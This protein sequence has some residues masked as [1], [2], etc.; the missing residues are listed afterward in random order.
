[1]LRS[2]HSIVRFDFDRMRVHPDRLRRGVDDDYLTAAKICLHHYRGGVG[3]TRQELHGEV[4]RTLSRVSG[5]PPRRIAAFCKLLDDSSTFDG[6]RKSAVKL[7][8]RVFELAAPLHPIVTTREG[9]FEHDLTTARRHVCQSLGMTWP[10]IESAMFGDVVEL[11][12]LQQFDDDVTPAE[13][14]S[15]YNVAQTQAVL[16]RAQRMILETRQDS[17]LILGQIKLAGLMHR[18]EKLPDG[19]GGYRFILDGPASGLRQTTRYGV[20]FAQMI[21]TLLHVS[22]WRLR[23]D[24]LTTTRRTMAFVLS[25]ADRLRP[26]GDRP[27]EFDSELEREIDAM[28]RADPVDD[29]TWHR[30][31]ELLVRGQSVL[32]PDFVAENCSRRHRMLV[33]V[34]GFWTPEYIAEKARRLREFTQV[35]AS[36]VSASDQAGWRVDWLLVFDKGPIPTEFESLGMKMIVLDR[37]QSPRSWL[38]PV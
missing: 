25:P 31:T 23:A 10:D 21:P 19:V 33:E 16:Y 36:G 6:D 9:I 38:P 17:R 11:Q 1:M 15:R 32:T 35:D 27:S 24:I 18:I 30:E 8:R 4:E 5:C 22:Q 34:V 12:T 26:S 29:W 2:E 14:L 7:R 3:R 20:R 13:F 28:W 37:R